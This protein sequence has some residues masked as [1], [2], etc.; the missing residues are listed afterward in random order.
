MNIKKNLFAI[1]PIA[2]IG[3]LLFS[4]LSFPTAVLGQAELTGTVIVNVTEEQGEVLSGANLLLKSASI[5]LTGISYKKGPY[6]F[7]M[8][9]AGKYELTVELQG[10]QKVVMSDIR[11]NFGETRIYNLIMK[12]STLEKTITITATQQIDVT[13][14]TTKNMID[15]EVIEKLAL[16]NRNFQD[17]LNLLPGVN[18]GM[19]RG[20][21]A[22]Q[23]GFRIDGV[24]NM[25]PFYSE[26]AME[27]SQKA[28]DRFELVPGGFQ[29][30]YGEFSGGIVNVTAKGGTNT[31][32]GH[33][34]T[35]YRGNSFASAPSIT[36]PGQVN[37]VAPDRRNFYE[38]ALGGP[39]VRDKLFFYSTLEYRNSRTGDIFEEKTRE[40][41]GYIGSLKL[42]YAQSPKDRW[43]F[44][45]G[46]NNYDYNNN[47]LDK[48]TAPESN[49]NLQSR[50]FIISLEQNH[51]FN[52]N[53]LLN[54][55][56]SI[57]YLKNGE[58]PTDPNAHITLYTYTPTGTFT[59]GRSP[60]AG[61][62]D[63]YRYRLTE[64]LT[65]FT[66]RHGFDFGLEFG[67]VVT[68]GSRRVGPTIFDLR[69]LG[70]P[71]S[72]WYIWQGQ[73]LY[74]LSGTEAAAYVQD[75]IHLANRLTVDAGVRVEYQSLNKNTNV[76]PRAGASY[77]LTGDRKTKVFAN[78]GVFYDRV[79]GHYV[80]WAGNK[81]GDQYNVNNPQGPLADGDKI[82]TWA[83]RYGLAPNEKTPYSV[84]WSVGVERLLPYG[85]KFTATYN[86]KNLHDQLLS[87]RVEENNI[88]L[89]QFKSNGSGTYRG[90]EFVL[91][92]EFSQNSQFMISY[93][94][95]RARGDGGAVGEFYTAVQLPP[96]NSIEDF[97][98]THLIKASGF[99][100]L[101]WD[102]WLSASLIYASGF[103][104]SVITGAQAGLYYVGGRNVN[105]MKPTQSLDFSLSK[106]FR[107]GR[108]RIG[109]VLEGYNVFNRTNI[110]SVSTAP[111]NHGEAASLDISRTFQLGLTFDF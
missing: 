110:L 52:P 7:V 111:E 85:M 4:F 88:L 94:L 80:Q 60:S 87:Y 14:S 62:F 50:K 69:P 91:S 107:F 46:Y 55:H 100:G 104:Y 57:L 41:L 98:R 66:G 5:K 33:F 12:A 15:P 2:T 53:L 27:F 3:L 8:V 24:N 25:D 21:R 30:K 39:L 11:V 79:F 86:Q 10:F 106:N 81:G 90:A 34:G 89:F 77:D 93:T 95:S 70:I 84:G 48:Y 6:K 23:T 64:S 108:S 61:S 49:E 45:A 17:V 76:A 35:Y 20:S 78:A 71:L 109:V 54:S 44:F 47:I 105:R 28:I 67:R 31:F 97:D 59:T 36:F 99:V 96:T 32:T 19:V 65:Y 72:Y 102:I 101:P 1:A 73:D 56:F 13:L 29:A 38:F 63:R 58:V 18:D 22:E 75:T 9:P 92:K 37:T 40:T 26:P 74:N 16:R 103:P 68:R 83:F 51:I 43:S 82:W 42:D